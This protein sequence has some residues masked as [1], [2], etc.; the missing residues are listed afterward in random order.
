MWRTPFGKS[1]KTPPFPPGNKSR[2]TLVEFFYA[3]ENVKIDGNANVLAEGVGL[4][5]EGI[6]TQNGNINIESNAVVHAKGT[7]AGY[8][9]D[10]RKGII[11]SKLRDNDSMR[12]YRSRPCTSTVV[13]PARFVGIKDSAIFEREKFALTARRISKFEETLLGPA[14][15][16]KR[17]FLRSSRDSN[18]RNDKGV[19]R[20]A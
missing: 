7:G 9:L 15:V 16:G 12:A 19:Y 13:M 1:S 8:A 14:F 3:H 18:R 20:K 17:I 11:M 2:L 10:C 6:R 4:N 5:S